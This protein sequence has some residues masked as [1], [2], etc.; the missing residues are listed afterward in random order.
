MPSGSR[1]FLRRLVEELWTPKLAQIF[2]YGKWLYPYR[3]LLHSASDLDQRC[4]KTRRSAVVAFL[5]GSHQISLPL[6]PKL[7]LKPHF[8]EPFNAKTIIDRALRKLHVNKATK[9]KNYSYIGIASTRAYV[10]IFP[11][12]GVQGAQGPLM[13]I[14]DP[15]NTHQISSSLP[16]KSSQNP[17]LG[18][19]QCKTYYR[20]L[21]VS[22]TLMELRS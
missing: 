10:K 11:P 21:F 6:P 17:I 16:R 9:L 3:I 13:Y 1:V 19:F 22:H 4:L 2:A 14:W 12:G 5:G 18:T 20:E 7:P 15:P 8:G